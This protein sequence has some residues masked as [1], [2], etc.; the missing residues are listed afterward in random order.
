MVFKLLKTTE[1]SEIKC[2]TNLNDC[3][4]IIYILVKRI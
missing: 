4:A 2:N 1:K 3:S